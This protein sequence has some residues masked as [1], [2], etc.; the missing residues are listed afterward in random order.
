MTFPCPVNGAQPEI[1]LRYTAHAFAAMHQLGTG[2]AKRL[3]AAGSSGSSSGGGSGSSS[4]SSSVGVSSGSSSRSGN[5]G[6]IGSI[7]SSGGDGSGGGGGGGGGDGG[8]GGGGSGSVTGDASATEEAEELHTA[9]CGPEGAAACDTS[10]GAEARK[11]DVGTE[12]N[13]TTENTARRKGRRG[14]RVATASGRS[15]R[16]GKGKGKAKENSGGVPEG[17]GRGCEVREDIA[18]GGAVPAGNSSG[19]SSSG[20][21]KEEDGAPPNELD[22]IML[23]KV[24]KDHHRFVRPNGRVVMYNLDSLVDYFIS[25]GDFLEPETRLPFSDDEL[26]TIDMKVGVGR[27]VFFCVS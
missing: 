17:K 16:K 22:P 11:P 10:G 13:R 19:N 9:D 15:S 21:E 7:G 12:A 14:R 3:P 6:S 1:E 4:G 2:P 27:F 18:P 5:S 26:R 20:A 23:I 8:G 24:G 25:T